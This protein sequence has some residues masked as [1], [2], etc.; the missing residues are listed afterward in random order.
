MNRYTLHFALAR[1][2]GKYPWK[3]K[4]AIKRAYKMIN[5]DLKII[6]YCFSYWIAK[7]VWHFSRQQKIKVHF[8]GID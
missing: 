6:L 7:T 8:D 1:P 4:I 2:G 3:L 5:G